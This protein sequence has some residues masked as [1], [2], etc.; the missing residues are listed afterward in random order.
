MEYTFEEL[1]LPGYGLGL[2]LYGT[3][4]LSDNGDGEFF[5]ETI[6]LDGGHVLVPGSTGLDAFLFGAIETVLYDP[7]T[8]DGMAALGHWASLKAGE[9]EPDSDYLYEQAR[10]RREGF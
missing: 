3:A 1:Q 4:L 8:D 9:V 2:L 10:D 5:V 6:V 7:R